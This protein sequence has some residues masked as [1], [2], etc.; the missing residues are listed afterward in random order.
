M[1]RPMRCWTVTGC[2]GRQSCRWVVALDVSTWCESRLTPPWVI[3]LRVRRSVA[4]T[5]VCSL[6]RAPTG[7]WAVKIQ[8]AAVLALETVSR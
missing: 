8:A 1:T 2:L 6:Q 5:L 7:K 4:V 3:V